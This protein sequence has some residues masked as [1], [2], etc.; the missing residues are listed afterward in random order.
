MAEENRK[1]ASTIDSTG[2]AGAT[3]NQGGVSVTTGGTNPGGVT[4][5]ANIGYGGGDF[6]GAETGRGVTD[7]NDK[8]TGAEQSSRGGAEAGGSGEAL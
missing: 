5:A 1:E 7:A 8:S 4:D 2:A 3:S 6:S